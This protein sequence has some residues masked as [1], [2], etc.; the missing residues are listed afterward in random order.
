MTDTCIFLK[1]APASSI[2]VF[3]SESQQAILS[4]KK[5]T[6]PCP[7]SMPGLH[8]R[9]RMMQCGKVLFTVAVACLASVSNAQEGSVMSGWRPFGKMIL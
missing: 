5:V 4:W 8:W 3:E 6:T 1:I 9:H 2:V 7:I